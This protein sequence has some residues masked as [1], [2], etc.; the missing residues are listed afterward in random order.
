MISEQIY[1]Y[2]YVPSSREGYSIEI[3]EFRGGLETKETGAPSLLPPQALVGPLDKL[4][5]GDKGGGGGGKR[6]G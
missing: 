4:L 1:I 2:I 5:R 3:L 6:G